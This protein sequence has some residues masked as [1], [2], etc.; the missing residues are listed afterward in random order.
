MRRRR[1]KQDS[2]RNATAE[3]GGDSGNM[4]ARVSEKLGITNTS[5]ISKAEG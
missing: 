5:Q 2:S 3:P 1:R 4:V